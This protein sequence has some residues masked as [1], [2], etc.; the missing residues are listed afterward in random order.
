MYEDAGQALISLASDQK[1]SNNKLDSKIPAGNIVGANSGII[2]LLTAGLDS[3]K[4]VDVNGVSIYDKLKNNID[5][6]ID[7]L[8]NVVV[9]EAII[10]SLGSIEQKLQSAVEFQEANNSNPEFSTSERQA[11]LGDMLGGVFGKK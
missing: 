5:F 8:S 10:D 7:D 4:L 9:N 11:A 6:Q 1:I 2:R 3:K